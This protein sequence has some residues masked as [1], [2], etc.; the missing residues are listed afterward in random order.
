MC[1]R[2][3]NRTTGLVKYVKQGQSLFS[4]DSAAPVTGRAE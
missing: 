3:M 2:L 4:T 1:H